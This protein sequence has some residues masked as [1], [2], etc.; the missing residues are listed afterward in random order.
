MLLLG[1]FD[2]VSVDSK[3]LFKLKPDQKD[4]FLA[5][6]PDAYRICYISDRL[7]IDKAR[8]NGETPEE[9]LKYVLPDPGNIMSGDFGELLCFLLSKEFLKNE[10]SHIGGPR[11]W[12]WKQDRNKPAPHTDILLFRVKDKISKGNHQD[13][14]VIAI[15]SKMKATKS[16]STHPI[17]DAIDGADK[18]RLSRMSK[19]LDWYNDKLALDKKPRL[20]SILTKFRKP[21]EYGTFK[22][23]FKAIAIIDD[24][25]FEEEISKSVSDYSSDIEIWSISIGQLKEAYE[26]VY[27]QIPNTVINEPKSAT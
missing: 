24:E 18:D 4:A 9:F 14:E 16:K 19:S 25:F 22:K 7:L 10:K 3:L 23:S 21:D 11:K 15:E 20:R 2:S 12:R 1:H 26:N 5:S 13:D 17:Q 27:R 6:L 8:A